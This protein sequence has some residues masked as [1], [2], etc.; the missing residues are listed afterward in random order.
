MRVLCL[1]I[2]FALLLSLQAVPAAAHPEVLRSDPPAGGVVDTAPEAVTI[3]FTEPIESRLLDVSVVSEGGARVDRGDAQRLDNARQVQVGLGGLGQGGYVVRWRALGFDGH[4]VAGAFNFGVGRAPT[5]QVASPVRAPVSEALTRWV[6]LL[7]CCLLVG[8]VLFRQLVLVPVAQSNTAVAALLPRIEE[9]LLSLIW[10]GFSIFLGASVVLLATQTLAAGR[11]A[12]LS[13][14]G[15]VLLGSRFGQLWIARMALLSALGAALAHFE[16]PSAGSAPASPRSA[17]RKAAR[18]AARSSG[19]GVG[20]R[21]M[22]AAPLGGRFPLISAVVADPMQ[23]PAAGEASG[24]SGSG[25]DAAAAAVLDRSRE[26]W[27]W[28]AA[29]L[30]VALLLLFS[31]GGHPAV[32]DAALLA[33][34]LDW[35]HRVAAVV[36]VGGT[37][38]LAVLWLARYLPP[39]SFLALLR[40]FSVVALA[41]VAVL[42]PTGIFAAW[43]YIPSPAQTAETPYG[44]VLL[45]KLALVAGMGA[46]GI[47]HWRSAFRPDGRQP[48]LARTL[49]TEALLGAAVLVAVGLLV[50]LAPAEGQNQARLAA[51]APVE[52]RQSAVS[53]ALTLADN[54][55]PNLVTLTIDPPR[56]GSSRLSMNVIDDVGRPVDDASITVRAIP[57]AGQANESTLTAVKQGVGRYTADWAAGPGRWDL[58][59]SVARPGQSEAVASFSADLPVPGARDILRRSDQTMNGLQSARE[60]QVIDGGA[61]NTLGV[62]YTYVAP[63]RMRVADDSGIEIVAALGQRYERRED[64]WQVAP[65]PDPR[66]FTWPTYSYANLTTDIRLLRIE[67]LDGRPHFVVA[68]ADGQ[69]IRYTF[70][71]D[72]GTYLISRERMLAPGHY[73]SATFSDFNGALSVE[74]PDVTAAP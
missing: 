1:G 59:V 5:G 48:L 28:I 6:T 26:Q 69:G 39:D 27:W 30:G 71:I 17:R 74:P 70:W 25:A 9:R 41:S 50:N 57:T 63:D 20:L 7:A 42:I 67:D 46:L 14:L 52:A 22:V 37:F 33:I 53:Q 8:G 11:E 31:L 29:G 23:R 49:V 12:G 44:V 66:G 2:L 40:R 3:T 60:H 61:G 15:E 18:S 55:G 68:F 24:G 34:P 51:A 13:R 73:M 54:A 16:S 47:L 19:E 58:E 32:T 43:A 64:Q 45:I 36:W 62:T 35:V 21:A 4:I 38:Y 10:A 72:T 65:W 56:P